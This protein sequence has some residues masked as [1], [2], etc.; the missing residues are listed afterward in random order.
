MISL[1]CKVDTSPMNI[2]NLFIKSKKIKHLKSNKKNLSK[3]HC[4]KVNSAD[5]KPYY[6]RDDRDVLH[7][8]TTTTKTVLTH[9]ENVPPRNTRQFSDATSNRIDPANMLRFEGEQWWSIR[10]RD[11]DL[12]WLCRVN[13]VGRGAVDVGGNFFCWN[14]C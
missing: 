6:L 4:L 3:E 10:S 2:S 13:H 9:T 1:C 7:A 14:R 5:D 11:A 12:W 8:I